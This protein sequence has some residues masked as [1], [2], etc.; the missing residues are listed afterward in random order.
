MK[1]LHRALSIFPGLSAR[2]DRQRARANELR[3]SLA[4]GSESMLQD[5]ILPGAYGGLVRIDFV[6]LTAGGI[7]CVLVRR[8]DGIVSGAADDPQ[9]ICARRSRRYRF[10]NPVLQNAARAKAIERTV[11]GVPVAS[12]IVIAG[13]AGFAA[14]PPANVITPDEIFAWLDRHGAD[15][16]PPEQRNAAW[17]S[18]NAAILTDDDSRKDFDAQLSFG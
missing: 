3:R 14:T 10:L 1:G 16:L 9:W 8:C 13:K 17:A 12:L 5:V 6:L 4:D 2:A 18:V 11:P 7:V 15:C